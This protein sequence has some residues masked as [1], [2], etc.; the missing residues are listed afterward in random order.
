MDRSFE[1]YVNIAETMVRYYFSNGLTFFLEDFVKK[2]DLLEGMYEEDELWIEKAL[3]FSNNLLL[4]FEYKGIEINQELKCK[5]PVV[6]ALN[7]SRKEQKQAIIR[8]FEHILR[9][10]NSQSLSLPKRV[11]EYLKTCSIEELGQMTIKSIAHNFGYKGRAHLSKLFKEEFGYT[12]QDAILYEKLNRAYK[13]FTRKNMEEREKVK[14]VAKKLGF[15]SPIYFSKVF[16]E[17]FWV[18]PHKLLQQP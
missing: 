11:N 6:F 17:K 16:K 5:L 13:I 14:D 2:L 18:K 4:A 7:K 8:A 15:S 3:V 9:F 12:L 10:Q 1:K